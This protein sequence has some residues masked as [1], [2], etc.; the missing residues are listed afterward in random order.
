MV[1]LIENDQVIN[2]KIDH[3]DIGNNIEVDCSD[4]PN[5]TS[6]PNWKNAEDIKCFNCPN[7]TQLPN[8]Q[9]VEKVWCFNCPGLTSPKWVI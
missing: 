3:I 6:L 7:L 4:C 2:G 1:F 8:W 5:L 9:K